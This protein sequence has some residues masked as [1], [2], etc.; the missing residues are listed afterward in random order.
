MSQSV[1]ESRFLCHVFLELFLFNRETIF[2]LI[3]IWM[4]S[5]NIV[6][7]NSA[8]PLS[9]YLILLYTQHT[10]RRIKEYDG[11]CEWV[12]GNLSVLH[13]H[14]IV[15]FNY[16]FTS[17]QKCGRILSSIAFCV[18]ILWSFCKDHIYGS[19]QIF[20]E[21]FRDYDLRDGEQTEHVYSPPG[22]SGNIRYFCF[23][24]WDIISARTRITSRFYPFFLA[25]ITTFLSF[26][27]SIS[28]FNFSTRLNVYVSWQGG[29]NVTF[30]ESLNPSWWLILLIC[31]YL[32]ILISAAKK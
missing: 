1:Q 32:F 26:S 22:T 27:V 30:G 14:H 28:N 2:H 15:I 20:L 3:S 10:Q 25:S 5:S 16:T 6:W 9:A 21:S 13:W 19:R 31:L 29:V 24:A 7:Q 8:F 23:T 17:C 4:K 12:S 18:Q 11:L